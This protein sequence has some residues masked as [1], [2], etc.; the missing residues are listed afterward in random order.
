MNIKYLAKTILFILL[1]QN[2]QALGKKVPFY[3]SPDK[4]PQETCFELQRSERWDTFIQRT[5]V[6]QKFC[7]K[8][9]VVEKVYTTQVALR[10]DSEDIP[11]LLFGDI[12]MAYKNGEK[13]ISLSIARQELSQK[14]SDYFGFA[15]VDLLF[16]VD[17]N[18]KLISEFD[19][20]GYVMESPDL[21]KSEGES[22]D[23]VFEKT[24]KY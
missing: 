11:H 22:A 1:I 9:V 24:L 23:L 13:R 17:Q 4:L 20:N 8:S 2:G 3:I 5:R 19:V 14:G 15:K 21:Q 18:G 10:V 6:P 12:L 16:T 7:V